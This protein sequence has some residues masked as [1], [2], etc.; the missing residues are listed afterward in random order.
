MEKTSITQ[1]APDISALPAVDFNK[2][3]FETLLLQK[4]YN[5]LLEKAIKCPCRGDSSA[6]H[7]PL[8]NCD[9]CGGSGW[10]FINR[11]KTKMV[12]MSMSHQTK[13][14]EWSEQKLGTVSISARDIDRLGEMDRLTVLDGETTFTEVIHPKDFEGTLF[15]FT[16]YEIITL[17]F[18]FLFKDAKTKLTVLHEGIDFTLENSKLIL[19]K[20][21]K[22]DLDINGKSIGLRY[23]HRPVYHVLDLVRDVMVTDIEGEGGRK[24]IQMPIHAMGRR[25][26]YIP[27]LENLEGARVFDNSTV[28]YP[29]KCS[30]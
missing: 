26:H 12:L 19:D 17:Q 7:Q 1:D 23:I 25:A 28:E 30:S 22:R 18:A 4:G 10:I 27:D 2:D 20:K 24:P 9:N 11:T 13:Y 15:C 21:Y 8:S 6:A 29:V 16:A 3:D 14:S 5:I